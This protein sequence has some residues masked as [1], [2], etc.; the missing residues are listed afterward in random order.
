MHNPNAAANQ[1]NLFPGFGVRQ[2]K[3]SKR[4]EVI[5]IHTDKAKQTEKKKY[6]KSWLAYRKEDEK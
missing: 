5:L 1:S 4:R 6:P 2:R 3:R